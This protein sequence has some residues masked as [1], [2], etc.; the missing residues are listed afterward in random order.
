M[1]RAE[2][3]PWIR[4]GFAKLGADSRG[5]VDRFSGVSVVSGV[6]DVEVRGGGVSVDILAMVKGGW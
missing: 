2:R 5:G 4:G 3:R 1:R 6:G